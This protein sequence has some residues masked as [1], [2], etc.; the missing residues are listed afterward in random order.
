M[1]PKKEAPK[2]PDHYVEI[3][4]ILLVVLFL[5]AIFMRIEQLLSYYGE[6]NAESLWARFLIYFFA[7]IWPIIKIVGAI[8]TAGCFVGIWHSLRSLTAV[9][10]EERLIYGPFP[11][12]ILADQKGEEVPR[13]DKWEHVIKLI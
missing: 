5:A 4:W 3:T 8:I 9:A 12:E 7:H 1:P 13:N 6:G 2:S 11:E 10:A